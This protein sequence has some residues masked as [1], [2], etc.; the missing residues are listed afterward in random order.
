MK[1]QVRKWGLITKI[2]MAA[3]AAVAL[4]GLLRP[5]SAKAHCDSVEGPVVAAARNALEAKDVAL[6]LPYV[7]TQ[8]P[9][10]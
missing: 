8:L 7:Q 3:A 5:S 2:G 6:V 1:A 10:L 4:I 9:R